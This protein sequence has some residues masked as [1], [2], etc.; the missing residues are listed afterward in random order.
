M[1]ALKQAAKQHV[2]QQKAQ[3]VQGVKTILTPVAQTAIQT[4]ASMKQD[5]LNAAQA[6]KRV[7]QQTLNQAVGIVDQ[8]ARPLLNSSGIDWKPLAQPWAD[9]ATA[10]MRAKANYTRDVSNAIQDTDF[11]FGIELDG[12]VNTTSLLVRGA[13]LNM[14]GVSQ[15]WADAAKGAVNNALKEAQPGGLLEGL[16][17]AIQ[18]LT[19]SGTS[20]LTAV[21]PSFIEGVGTTR[22]L[23]MGLA[24]YP[25]QLAGDAAKVAREAV[26]A[27]PG[28]AASLGTG[29]VSV[30]PIA[31]PFATEAFSIGSN[32]ALSA[33][34]A[35][36]DV[37][38]NLATPMATGAAQSAR[39][40]GS[41][42]LTNGFRPGFDEG[43]RASME[44]RA[45]F[46]DARSQ[47]T[48]AQQQPASFLP[49]SF[50]PI[51]Q[52]ATIT[53]PCPTGSFPGPAGPQPGVPPV[54]QPVP[55]QPGV[56]GVV[57]PP[58]APV[59][60]IIGPGIPCGVPLYVVPKSAVPRQRLA[61][62]VVTP[63]PV[64]PPVSIGPHPAPLCAAVC[65]C[66][67]RRVLTTAPGCC[68]CRSLCCPALR[69]PPCRPPRFPVAAFPAHPS[70]LPS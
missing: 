55:G 41:N 32:A 61:P 53:Y 35:T 18:G 44:R 2:M 29:A 30:L 21:T 37:M 7:K 22:N 9:A 50:A 27:L 6:A 52:M 51:G 48:Q 47:R 60:T 15:A 20:L 59:G 17:G 11:E 25:A 40:F 5:V 57:G 24:Q 64:E 26:T 16:P 31:L 67:D 33:A 36:G 62:P 49:S 54:P 10:I 19:Q 69:P 68:C 14:T 43:F 23:G 63:I 56:P 45:P 42:L 66:A 28:A 70:H 65:V 34:R 39:S 1:D 8:A 3:T 12:I 13:V 38:H 4:K 46:T 58:T